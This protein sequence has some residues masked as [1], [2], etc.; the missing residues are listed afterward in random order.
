MHA[1]PNKPAA[2]CQMQAQQEEDT[3]ILTGTVRL[4][5]TGS[6]RPSGIAPYRHARPQLTA[7]TNSQPCNPL[8]Y[9]T[10]HQTP[11]QS[12]HWAPTPAGQVA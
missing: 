8:P 1:G 12:L 2:V 11:L 3:K 7:D 5:A 6:L 9:S 4:V 10:Q